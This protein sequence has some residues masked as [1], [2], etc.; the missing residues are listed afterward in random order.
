MGGEQHSTSEIL[1][2]FENR[3]DM[4]Q[5]FEDRMRRDYSKESLPERSEVDTSLLKTFLL[6]AHLSESATLA[7]AHQLARRVFN[8]AALGGQ[9]DVVVTK[10]DD[11]SLIGVH[12]E[13]SLGSVDLCLDVA[14]PRFWIAHSISGSAAVDRLVRK[15]VRSGPQLDRAWL[16]IQMLEHLATLGRFRAL[17][18]D[19]DRRAIKDVDFELPDAPV[20]Y[21]KMQLAGNRSAEVLKLLRDKGAY[22]S[23]TALSKVKVKYWENA[24]FPELFSVDEVKFDGRIAVRGL[25]FDSHIDFVTRAYDSYQGKLRHFEEQFSIRTV[26]EHGCVRI[27]GS[28][29]LFRFERF[30]RDL[31]AFC[32]SLFA[33]KE[34]F[35]L[36]GVPVP[37]GVNSFRVRGVDL[38]VGCAINFEI[39]PEWIRV[40]LPAGGCGNTVLRLF[41]NLQ[42][43]YDSM[44]SAHDEDG[45]DLFQF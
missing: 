18:L 42:H 39:T 34:P 28:P 37:T 14:N 16:P 9:A 20:A 40:Y 32:E 35:R 11:P 7:K 45:N 5:M 26:E 24:D 15:A 27:D 31:P 8:S 41:T 13:T 1:V 38:H 17:S 29:I 36:W 21:L 10:L 43:H 33:S 30:I 23:E 2:Q 22:A 19:F 12:A 6:E 3:A 25:S 44:I 4:A